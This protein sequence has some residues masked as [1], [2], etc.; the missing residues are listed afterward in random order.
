MKNMTIENIAASCGGVLHNCDDILK[1]E[2]T[3][4]TTDSRAVTAGNLFIAM[5]G[6][7]D[8][9]DFVPSALNA[10]AACVVVEKAD[11]DAGYPYIKVKKTAVAIQ[12]IAEFYRMELGI[13][14]VGIT[15]SVGKTSTKEMIASVLA[16]KYNVLKT[17]GNFNNNLGLPLTI[18][19]LREEHEIAVLEMGISHFGEMTDLARTA[20]PDTM[21]ITN[22]GTCHLEFLKDRDGVFEAK[23]EC[24]EYVDFTHGV[25]VL[26]GEDDKLAQVDQVHGRAPIFYGRDASFRVYA[27]NIVPHGIDGISCTICMDDR[28]FD[29]MIPVPGRHQVLNALA[30]AAVGS[31]YGLTDEE[32]KAGIESLEPIGGRFR[33]LHK[34]GCTVIDDCYNANPMSMKASLSVLGDV[35]ERTVAVLGDMGEL[36]ENEAALHREVGEA[37]GGMAVDAFIL[38]G[39]LSKNIAEGIRSV[40][41]DADIAWFPTVPE[42][43]PEIKAKVGSGDVVLVKAS[44][45]MQFDRIVDALTE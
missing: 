32:I 26:N 14:V 20:R 4:V 35:E 44:H 28:E 33:G 7:H 34:N 38:I 39:E 21:V 37:A 5:R 29:V 24:F 27:E 6:T 23:T 3:G 22:I 31:V 9:H 41:P 16:Q 12:R 42:A 18:F 30:G 19:R 40:R 13:P 36:G 45:F 11:Q 1:N 25:V 8:G 43:V 2:V 10:G 15:G 17:A